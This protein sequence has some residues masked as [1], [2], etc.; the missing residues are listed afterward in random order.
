MLTAHHY[1]YRVTFNRYWYVGWRTCACDP[2]KDPY[3]PRADQMGPRI[4]YGTGFVKEI[5]AVC[6]TLKEARKVARQL[7]DYDDP[8]CQNKKCGPQTAE[9][10]ARISAA[11]RKRMASPEA[12]L[13]ASLAQIRRWGRNL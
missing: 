1:V 9:A 6:G 4:L 12:R 3:V 10:R 8:F 2:K 7:T 11:L 5:L 13:K